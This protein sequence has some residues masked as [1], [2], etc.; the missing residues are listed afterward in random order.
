MAGKADLVK[1]L[2]DMRP[3]DSL[4]LLP[5]NPRHGDIGAISQSLE[6]FGQQKPI[7]INRD[8]MILAGN[9]TFQAAKALGWEEIWVAESELE[10]A[11]QPG[12]ALA[13]N[14]L[15]DLATYDHDAL[16]R[17]LEDQPNLDG[18]GYSTEDMEE[19]RADLAQR[20]QF[21]PEIDG[22]R[23]DQLGEKGCRFPDC[24]HECQ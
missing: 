3:V 20:L 22:A 11:D 6:R 13:D 19:I 4:I 7:V 17:Y 12:F 2:R 18:T 14:R 24:G 5:D 9:H 21:T 10:G 1:K 16:L 15:S 23:L 8:G